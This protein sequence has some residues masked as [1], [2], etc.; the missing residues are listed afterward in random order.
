MED[1]KVGYM[2]RIGCDLGNGKVID[3]TGNFPTGASVKEMADELD[4]VEMAVD[5]A[6][7][8]VLLS[9]EEHKLTVA[10][11]HESIVFNDLAKFEESIRGKKASS[12]DKVQQNNLTVNLQKYRNDIEN[13][14]KSIESLK[15]LIESA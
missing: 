8:K 3:V 10:S 2:F 11:H 1:K 9:Q 13:A 4:K 14:K 6:R 12:Q 15:Q 7:A 5:R